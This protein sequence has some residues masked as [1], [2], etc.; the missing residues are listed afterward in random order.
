MFNRKKC[1]AVILAMPTKTAEEILWDFGW[2]PIFDQCSFV[3]PS[4]VSEFFGIGSDVLDSLNTR[5]FLSRAKRLGFVKNTDG[6][7]LYN[8][9]AILLIALML[10]SYRDINI[11]AYDAAIRIFQ[12]MGAHNL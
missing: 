2:A 5:V 8:A 11:M 3:G 4:V 10:L 6:Y 7:T 1:V 12:Y 9:N